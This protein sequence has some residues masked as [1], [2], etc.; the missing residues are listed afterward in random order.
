MLDTTPITAQITRM[1]ATGTTEQAL[2]SA[3]ACMLEEAVASSPGLTAAAEKREVD[4]ENR[5]K[6]CQLDLYAD[7][8]PAT[9]MR[10]NQLRLWFASYGRASDAKVALKAAR[11][12]W[13]R[14]PFRREDDLGEIMA[15]RHRAHRK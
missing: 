2:L 3:V 7:R 8:T 12:V 4:M 9:T 11:L 6:E 14:Y 5:I 13:Q 15:A 1:I 10:A